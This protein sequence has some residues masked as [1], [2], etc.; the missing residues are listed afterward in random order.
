MGTLSVTIEVGDGNGR[1]FQELEALVDTG[2][3]YLVVPRSVLESLGV[4]AAERRPFT[5]ADGRQTEYDV[6]VTTLRLERR[7]FPVLTVFGDND[8]RALLGAVALETFGLAADPVR[9]RLVA[10]SGLLMRAFASRSMR[11]T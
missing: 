4:A 3:S 8:V 5:L 6:G 7:T 11:T 10:V 9:Q 2:A 1:S